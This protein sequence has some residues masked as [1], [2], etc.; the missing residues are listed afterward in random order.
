MRKFG[1]RANA[2]RLSEGVGPWVA[3]CGTGT[4]SS[5]RETR[6]KPKSS[7][8]ASSAWNRT[9][10]AGAGVMT[11]GRV[12]LNSMKAAVCRCVCAPSK[13]GMATGES[14]ASSGHDSGSAERARLISRT[15]PARAVISAGRVPTSTSART[16]FATLAS[17]VRKKRLPPSV[18]TSMAPALSSGVSYGFMFDHGPAGVGADS[19]Q[20][21]TV[22][23]A[24]A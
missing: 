16:S 13:T 22:P 19:V 2:A 21:R 18:G 24:W 7:G 14:M 10:G 6:M 11:R 9:N 5:E 23:S 20:T 1:V 15:S 17:W 8:G 3:N 4:S 12:T